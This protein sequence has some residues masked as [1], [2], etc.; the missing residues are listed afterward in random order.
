MAS[1]RRKFLVS[2]NDGDAVEIK[3]SARDVIAASDYAGND[4]VAAT[5]G[6]LYAALVRQGYQVPPYDEWIDLVDEV[7]DVGTVVTDMGNPT[8]GAASVGAPLPSPVSPE[9]T[10]DPGS[11]ET[12]E[13]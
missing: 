8:N 6:L 1:L 4:P 7:E 3:T 13:P 11:T 12:P 5:F 9:P 2:W 10:G